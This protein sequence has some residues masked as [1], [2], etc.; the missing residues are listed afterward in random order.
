M[1]KFD[2]ILVFIVIGL[3]GIGILVLYSTTYEW[4]NPFWKKQLIWIGISLLCLFGVSF[5]DYSILK[6]YS[7]VI[8]VISIILLFAVL[9]TPPVR[10]SHSWF[11]IGGISIQPSEFA[12]L[13]II[14]FLSEY[15]KDKIKRLKSPLQFIPPFIIVSIPVFLILLQPDIGSTFVF[16]V[17]FFV[18]LYLC[19]PDRFIFK[20]LLSSF[21]LIGFGTIIFSFLKFKGMNPWSIFTTIFIGGC[22]L[23]VVTGILRYKNKKLLVII[24]TI[25]FSIFLSITCA[26]CLKE[27]QRMRLII[28]LDPYIDSFFTGYNIIQSKIA[29]GSGGV[30]G[31][32]FLKGTQSHLGF[33]PERAT[34]FIFSVFAEEFGFIGIAVLVFLVLSLVLRGI[35]ISQA[36]LDPF[37]TLLA[38]G[39]SVMIGASFFVNM[40]ICI[41]ILPVTGIPLPFISYGGSS[42]FVNT[43]SVGILVSIRRGSSYG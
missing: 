14:I 18:L 21:L 35:A 6:R 43:V 29:V 16:F 13:A 12:K 28:F 3:L 9:F 31:K 23:F 8:Y 30:Y 33:L 4:K 40:G 34:D 39:I 22:I 38:C 25:V 20:L 15:L 36:T 32:G 1:R 10:S 41:G 17:I 42:L 11:R 37:A 27:Y 7:L 2:W 26:Y 5:V 19:E 24:P